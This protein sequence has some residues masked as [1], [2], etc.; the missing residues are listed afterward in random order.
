MNKYTKSITEKQVE[1]LIMNT[2]NKNKRELE[3]AQIKP[4]SEKW[5]YAT[6]GIYFLIG[7]MSS[8]KSYFLWKHIY[9]SENLFKKPYYQKIIFCSTSGKLDKTSEFL[10][11]NIKTPIVYISEDDLIPFLH[12][13]IKRKSKYYSI[14]KHVLSKLKKAD[15]TMQRLINKYDLDDIDDRI[16]YIAQKLAQYECSEYPYNTLLILDDF[17]GS[18]LLTKQHSELIRILT[19]TRHYNITCIIAIQTFRSVS[20]NVKRLAT[21]VIVYAGFSK[22]DCESILEQTPNNL[23]KKT[24]TAQYLSLPG[25]H[26]RMVLNISDN[27]M[28]FEIENE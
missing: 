28:H 19:K 25:N 26:D 16:N 22:E 5:K 18:P 3:M 27:S 14:V 1:D 11:K 20:K 24:T 9:M 12:R 2:I 17:A 15:E 13:H 7:K 8:G 10:S 21:D 23:D 6:N 4:M